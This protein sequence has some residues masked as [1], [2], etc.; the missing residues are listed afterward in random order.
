MIFKSIYSW[1]ERT[2]INESLVV[3]TAEIISPSWSEYLRNK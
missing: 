2:N 1:E 3:Y